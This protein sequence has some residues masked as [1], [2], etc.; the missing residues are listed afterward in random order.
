MSNQLDIP[1]SRIQINHQWYAAKFVDGE[2][3]YELSQGYWR[4]AP[5][6]AQSYYDQVRD[7][8]NTDGCKNCG[9]DIRMI[10]MSGTGFCSM[11]CQDEWDA[12]DLRRKAAANA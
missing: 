9:G 8:M 12:E 3:H 4:R 2:L 7:E 1:N 10:V 11:N 5:K 6:W